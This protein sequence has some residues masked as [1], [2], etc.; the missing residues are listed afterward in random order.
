[1]QHNQW[2]KLLGLTLLVTLAMTAPAWGTPSPNS[3]VVLSR[4][5]NDCPSSVLNISNDYPVCIGID[6]QNAG[7]VGF[8]N[9]HAWRFSEDGASAVVFNN[10]DGFRFGADL[11]ISGDGDGEAGLQIA[12]WWSQADGR[13]NVRTTDG[14][15]ACFGGRLP[16]YSFTASHGLTYTKGTTIRL[17]I[18]YRPNGLSE[19]SPATI[20]YKVTYDGTEYTSGVLAFDMGNSNEDPPYGLW[21][22][23]N[24]ARVGGHFQ[25]F[26]ADSGATGQCAVQWCNIQY[27]ASPVTATSSTWSSVKNLFR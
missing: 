22:I 21:G 11:T 5:F 16:F 26:V 12:P 20:E 25:F 8:A 14:E 3:A 4:I 2:L 19:P 24:D 15:I 1:M 23:L 17:D 10:G 27:E 6:D 7:C 13:F 9:L 18:D